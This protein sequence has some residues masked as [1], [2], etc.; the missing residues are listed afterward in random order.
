MPLIISEKSGIMITI[1]LVS[2]KSN[3]GTRK[4]VSQMKK[5]IALALCIVTVLT[6]FTACTTLEEGDKG[7]VIDIYL[8]NE[9]YNF[10]PAM[11]YNDEAMVKV[12]SLIYEGLTSL[13][14]NGKWQKALMKSYS[15][16]DNPE[17]NDYR[18]LIELNETKWSDGRTVQAADVVFAWKRILDPEFKSEAASLLFDIKNAHAAKLGDASIDDVGV[19]AVETYV[20]EVSFD[21][22]PDLDRFFTN[23]SSCALVPL[24]E[25]VVAK[26][27]DWAR[28][29]TSI[30]TNGP[31]ALKAMDNGSR[32]R[33]E[34]SAYY[35]L[36]DGASANSKEPLDKYVIPYRLITRY[37][38][39]DLEAQLQAFKDGKVLY[40]GEIPLS[41]RQEYK[42]QAVVNDELNTHTY[43]FN[44][45]N[46][47]FE[48][49]DVR[50]ALSLAIDR[51]KIANEIVVFAKAATGL[52]PG[53]VYDATLKTYFR[54]KGGDL[55]KTSADVQAAKSLLDK[56]GVKG[57]EFTITVRDNEED[58][59]IAE[60]IAGVWGS[61]GFTVKVDK[62]GCKSTSV[63]GIY[64]DLYQDAYN[65]GDFDVIA[66]DLQMLAPSAI[67]A[68]APFSLEYSGNG[69]DMNSPAYDLYTHV[70][71]FN[72]ADYN[73]LIADA[74]ATHDEAKRTELLHKAEE[75]LMKEMP[76]MPVVFTQDAYLVNKDQLSG[77]KET[78]YASRDFKRMKQKNYYQ[79]KLENAT[80][81]VK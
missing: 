42:N 78:Y 22:K 79:Y 75:L 35:Y 54:E 34:R 43:Y 11:N 3:N 72:N 48:N 69:V 67:G 23:V 49:A 24:R 68:L 77:I 32:L 50:N 57:G 8:A 65:A 33:I 5:I 29:A 20:L 7:M 12:F 74:Y 46:P 17:K 15:T 30:T 41:A 4:K 52:I 2:H 21:H 61:L 51:D 10:D 73:K 39:G 37:S 6:A 56:A 70:T 18:V 9:M 36:E 55:I 14:A 44:T 64:R 27:A 16:K 26:N 28:K 40:L 1:P 66:V 19:K 58:V 71:G 38:Y 76:V 80:E 81:E 53:K 45:T 25:D 59:A 47:L 63:E 62:L 60:Y 31:F 13:D